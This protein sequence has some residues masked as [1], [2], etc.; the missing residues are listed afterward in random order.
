V[1]VTGAAGGIGRALVQAFAAEGARLALCAHRRFADLLAAVAAAEWRERA[2]CL[3]ADVTRPAEIDAA[4]EQAATRFGRL[5]ACIAN[6]GSWPAEERPLHEI[7]EQR[8]RRTVE[9]NLLGAAFTARAFLSRLART[10]P[11]ADG[12]GAA[13]V[14]IGSTAGRFGERGHA[15]YAMAKAGLRGLALSLKNE[16]ARVDPFG[17][18]NVLEPGWT[19][20]SMARPALQDDAALERVAGTM[21]L[22]QLGRAD[23]VARAA[24]FLA[25]PIAARHLSG[26]FLAVAGGM[27]GRLLWERDEVDAAAIR[28]RLAPDEMAADS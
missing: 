28:A 20:T 6:A 7:D 26:E 16:I 23:D 17:R 9:V 8:L 13:L 14:L 2:L 15:D 5:D 12:H 19:V 25:S 1:V 11:R 3:S 10:G 27:E 24:L 21:A 4:L 22:R 18:V